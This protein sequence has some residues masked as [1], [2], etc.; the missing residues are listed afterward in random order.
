M[1]AAG[2]VIAG[3][4]AQTPA[5]TFACT[6]ETPTLEAITVGNHLLSLGV[7]AA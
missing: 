6:G 4:L 2:L 5:P 7:G 1:A 3:M